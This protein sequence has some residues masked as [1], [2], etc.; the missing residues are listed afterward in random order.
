[1]KEQKN[2]KIKTNKNRKTKGNRTYSERVRA[3]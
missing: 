3:K 1:M 2:R